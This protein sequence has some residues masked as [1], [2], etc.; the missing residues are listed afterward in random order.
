[1]KIQSTSTGIRVTG[2]MQGE[3]VRIYTLD[4]V[5]Q[6]SVVVENRTTD[7]PMRQHGIYII[8]VGGKVVKLKY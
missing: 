8:R 2:A 7:I 6:K 1:M 4:G 5:L 3:T